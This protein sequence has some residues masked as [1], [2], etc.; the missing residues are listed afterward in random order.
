MKQVEL[1]KGSGLV[2]GYDGPEL[3]LMND[4]I[5]SSKDEPLEAQRQALC[6]HELKVWFGLNLVT[7]QER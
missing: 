6:M 7:S 2:A 4:L 5:D 1:P 3:R